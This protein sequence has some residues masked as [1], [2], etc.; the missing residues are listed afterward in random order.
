MA[1]IAA[2]GRCEPK[3]F[4]ARGLGGFSCAEREAITSKHAASTAILRIFTGNP[5][6]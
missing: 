4:S 5:K 1:A 2:G 6:C 3:R